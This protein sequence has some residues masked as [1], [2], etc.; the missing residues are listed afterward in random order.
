MI[1]IGTLIHL[2]VQKSKAEKFIGPL[3][4]TMTRYNIVSKLR[5]CHFL[6]QV[7]HESANLYYVRELASGAEYDTGAK[8]K[9]L[10]N[11][12]EADGDGQKYKG[13]GLIQITGHD[14]YEVLGHVFMQDF[15]THP[16]QLE[17]PK[18]AA[19]SAGWFWDNRHLNIFADKDDVTTITKRINGGL[20]G[21]AARMAILESCKA[22]IV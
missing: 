10:G 22:I 6:A 8:A 12:P 17:E 20:N 11:T 4:E 5:V 3:T 7:L 19:T 16:E 9:A 14:N 2:G 15:L 1:T 18:W 13:R 21:L